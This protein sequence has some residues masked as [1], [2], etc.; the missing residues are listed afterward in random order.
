MILLLDARINRP[1]PKETIWRVLEKKFTYSNFL[2]LKM[3]LINECN[4]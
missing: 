2:F 3:G 4:L 1:P